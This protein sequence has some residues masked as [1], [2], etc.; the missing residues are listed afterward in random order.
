[1]TA[2]VHHGTIEDV[3]KEVGQ[4]KIRYGHIVSGEA[5]GTFA[6]A[7]PE[8]IANDLP[9]VSVSQEIRE[10]LDAETGAPSTH[11]V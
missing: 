11:E 7:E 4:Q 2:K 9:G 10:K 6:V 3:V 8:R 1:M 5:A